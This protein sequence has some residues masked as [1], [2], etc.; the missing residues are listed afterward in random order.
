MCD[1]CV[2]SVV[3][4]L[5]YN[6]L[7]QF[8]HFFIHFF[9]FFKKNYNNGNIFL[10][11]IIFI[12]LYYP[13]MQ[14]RKRSSWNPSMF[15]GLEHPSAFPSML[16]STT[17]QNPLHN[18]QIR[19][20]SLNKRDTYGSMN[21]TTSSNS[22]NQSNTTK[23]TNGLIRRE[24]FGSKTLNRRDSIGSSILNRR[25]SFG[26]TILNRRDSFGSTAALVNNNTNNRRDS[27][28]STLS[29]GDSLDLKLNMST[30]RD[31]FTGND[32]KRQSYGSSLFLRTDSSGNTNLIRRDSFGSQN[33]NRRRSANSM[34]RD[35][36][37]RVV[38]PTNT[39]NNNA[40]STNSILRKDSW[41]SSNKHVSYID[42]SIEDEDEVDSGHKLT[43]AN[44]TKHV[45]IL[46][47]NQ[48]SDAEHRNGIVGKKLSFDEDNLSNYSRERRNSNGSV[49][50]YLASRRI[51]ID[52]LETRR[53]S[54]DRG[55]RGS[56]SSNERDHLD[57]VKE[58]CLFLILNIP[59][60]S[61]KEIYLNYI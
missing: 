27:F 54:W 8:N 57:D 12:R 14:N 55:R 13:T 44:L 9:F 17:S 16:R 47:G 21:G 33:L 39:N 20:N 18:E 15:K 50:S 3:I 40:T 49:G 38:E 61:F 34:P 37:S 7:F 53:N 41:K 26:S 10:L 60:F 51:S 4:T 1:L 11:F 59:C 28:G 58:V 31:T 36:V 24:S 2:N 56:H 19:A 45:T 42:S 43:A 25:E 30:K 35:Y 48:K 32:L 23:P 5:Y 29:R 22:I 46:E 52:S 6:R